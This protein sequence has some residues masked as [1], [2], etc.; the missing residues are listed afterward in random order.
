MVS[1][2]CLPE[3]DPVRMQ[4]NDGVYDVTKF[5]EAHPVRPTGIAIPPAF[6]SVSKYQ[7][8]GYFD[9]PFSTHRVARMLSWFMPD[10]TPPS[11]R[12]GIMCNSCARES[13]R[14]I[15][16]LLFVILMALVVMGDRLL[17]C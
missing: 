15:G 12:V 16:W 9:P 10:G 1:L 13:D 17:F 4:I 11:V 7:W 14:A 5:I 8:F 2:V 6:F 3:T